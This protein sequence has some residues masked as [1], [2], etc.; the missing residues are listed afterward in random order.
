MPSGPVTSTKPLTQQGISN[1]IAAL[2]ADLARVS[3]L[4]GSALKTRLTT[5]MGNLMQQ[6]TADNGHAPNVNSWTRKF[7]PQ[8]Q[9]LIP[10][11][12]SANLAGG[13]VGQ[14][15]TGAC[16]YQGGCIQSTKAQCDALG[17]DF[18]A[19]ATCP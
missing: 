4:R 7:N 16:A 14:S 19:G 15:A 18:F 13:T 8:F 11:L 2:G 3:Q 5:E 12:T 17:G 10:D 6:L 1:L 9:R